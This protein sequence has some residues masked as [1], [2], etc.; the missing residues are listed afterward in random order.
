MGEE[1][2][3]GGWAEVGLEEGEEGVGQARGFLV[4]GGAD[5]VG[6]GVEYEEGLFLEDAVG[7]VE[8]EAAGE[9]GPELDGEEV[10]VAGG[11]AVAEVGFDDGKGDLLLL[12][13]KE[14]GA[15]VTEKFAAG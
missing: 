15:E 2:L 12:E 8:A 10:V 4:G 6:G 7:E 11:C 3:V 14:S 13:L 1:G 9:G 5:V